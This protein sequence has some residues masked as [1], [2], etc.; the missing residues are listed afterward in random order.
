[1]T[2]TQI[3]K[4]IICIPSLGFSEISFNNERFVYRTACSLD[5]TDYPNLEEVM[6]KLKANFDIGYA[7]S[8]INHE[9]FSTNWLKDYMDNNINIPIA[10]VFGKSIDQ[11]L[12]WLRC[13][14]V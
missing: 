13:D 3:L 10:Y 2:K 11:A 7:L 8:T 4:A 6:L 9:Y 5:N 12:V 14:Q 1:M